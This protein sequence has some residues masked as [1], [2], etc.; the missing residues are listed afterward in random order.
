[1]WAAGAPLE[2]AGAPPEDAAS[3]LEDAGASLE[4][5]VWNAGALELAAALDAAGALEDVASP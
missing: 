1:M 3:Q 4:A 5:T 2:D